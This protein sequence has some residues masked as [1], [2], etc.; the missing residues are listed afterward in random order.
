M[1]EILEA[2]VDVQALIVR[3]G[4]V[5]NTS[6][7]FRA[8]E[9]NEGQFANCFGSIWVDSFDGNAEDKVGTRRYFVG[10]GAPHY[11]IFLALLK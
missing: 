3:F 11:A 7:S 9:V 2:W 8:S 5:A 10:V 1:A 4:I 6:R